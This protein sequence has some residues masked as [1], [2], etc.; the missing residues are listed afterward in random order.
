MFIPT[1][2]TM[3]QAV[4]YA[5][6]HT[7][8]KTCLEGHISAGEYSRAYGPKACALVTDGWLAANEGD[9]AKLLKSML[10]LSWALPPSCFGR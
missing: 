6:I 3:D 4:R 7:P 10:A 5:E 9:Q 2:P 8:L 1:F